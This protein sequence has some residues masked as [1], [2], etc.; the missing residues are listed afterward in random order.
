MGYDGNQT[1]RILQKIAN[2]PIM[3]MFVKK[4]QVNLIP[5]NQIDLV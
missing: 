4:F 1:T 3:N 2:D 5:I